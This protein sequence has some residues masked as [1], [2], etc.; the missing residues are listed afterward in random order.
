LQVST[1]QKHFA[2]NKAETVAGGHILDSE[3]F[4]PKAD[5]EIGAEKYFYI[6]ELDPSRYRE[7]DEFDMQPMFGAPTP[8]RLVHSENLQ[9]IFSA[10]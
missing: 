4:G 3:G 10:K 8:E 1:Q 5:S 6:F 2:K 9:R 7:F